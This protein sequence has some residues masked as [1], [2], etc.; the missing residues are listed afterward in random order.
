MQDYFLKVKNLIICVS[1]TFILRIVPT[2][3]PNFCKL[4]WVIT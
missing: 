3:I 2:W 1:G 4:L